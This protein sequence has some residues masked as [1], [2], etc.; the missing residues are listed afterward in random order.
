MHRRLAATAS[1]SLLHLLPSDST[2]SYI[3][4]SNSKPSVFATWELVHRRSGAA[5]TVSQGAPAAQSPAAIPLVNQTNQLAGVLANPFSGQHA[6][7]TSPV[8]SARVAAPVEQVAL[9]PASL[10]PQSQPD[11]SPYSSRAQSSELSAKGL[12]VQQTAH[13]SIH[14]SVWSLSHYKCTSAKI[15]AQSGHSHTR[16]TTFLQASLLS[17]SHC[18]TACTAFRLVWTRVCVFIDHDRTPYRQP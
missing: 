10:V 11:A 15:R 2:E 5:A 6:A 12:Q 14:Y 18:S 4:L 17:T 7:D 9:Q 16:S 13:S 1:R 3:Q 8:H